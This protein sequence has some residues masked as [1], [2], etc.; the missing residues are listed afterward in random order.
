M[1]LGLCHFE[2]TVGL[3]VQIGREVDFSDVYVVNLQP[4]T[5]IVAALLK[6]GK[7]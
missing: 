3:M 2:T 7:P 5:G 6:V 1:N 4:P